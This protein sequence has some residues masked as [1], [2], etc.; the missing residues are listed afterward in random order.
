MI[1][2]YKQST[3]CPDCGQSGKGDKKAADTHNS[4]CSYKKKHD[5]LFRKSSVFKGR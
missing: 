1:K 3:Y 2:G 5:I 4:V